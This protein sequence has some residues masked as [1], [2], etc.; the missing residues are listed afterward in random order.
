MVG[1]KAVGKEISKQS[2]NKVHII[3]LSTASL[4][5]MVVAETHPAQ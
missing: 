5:F 3:I 1:G 2:N 4:V